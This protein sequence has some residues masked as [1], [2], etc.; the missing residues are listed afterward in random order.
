MVAPVGVQPM[1]DLRQAAGVG[2]RFVQGNPAKPAPT[3]AV[4]Y[5]I[6]N[7]PVAKSV[8]MLERRHAQVGFRW[9]GRPP[10]VLMV[11]VLKG[12]EETF[13]IQPG[14]H[15]GQVFRELKQLRRQQLIQERYLAEL[16]LTEAQHYFSPPQETKSVR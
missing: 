12:C 8:L 1:P 11:F 13:I 3:N 6:A 15:F 16:F 10:Q 4:P 7:F 2:Y 14:V 9:Y 5:L